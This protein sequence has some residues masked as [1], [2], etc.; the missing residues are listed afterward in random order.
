MFQSFVSSFSQACRDRVEALLLPSQPSEVVQDNIEGS[1]EATAAA[2]AAAT[3][4]NVKTGGEEIL[5]EVI[6]PACLSGT[7]TTTPA[8]TAT[9]ARGDSDSTAGAAPLPLYG[10]FWA[11]AASL[12]DHRD[13]FDGDLVPF[14]VSLYPYI[15]Y[16]HP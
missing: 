14:V 13:L 12:F 2:V 15:I 16:I 8:A 9:T 11:C 10:S 7:T 1:A 6:P 5:V 4:V 3:T